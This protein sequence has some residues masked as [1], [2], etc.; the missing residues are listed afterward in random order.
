[1]RKFKSLTLIAFTALAVAGCSSSG[2]EV[3]D[4]TE[5]E[6]Y[7]KSQTYLQ[8]GD[9]SQAIRYLEAVKNRFPG[10]SYSEQTQLNLIYAYYKSQDY[11]KTLVTA[12]RFIQQFP[13]SQNLDY[14]LYMTGLTNFALGENFFQDFFGVD[15]ATRES[16]S[17]K[18]AFANFQTLVQHFPNSAYAQD[19]LARMAYI[20]ASLAR[21]ELSIAKFYAKRDAHVAV[22]NRVVGM[23][24]QYSDTQATLD[25]LP[26]MKE[27]YEKMNLTHLAN[28]TESLIQ[29]NQGKRFA[30][31]EKPAEPNL[32]VPQK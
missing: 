19:A 31:V 22:A 32:T 12:D 28:Q 30:D 9:Y 20:K 24:Q 29:A 4:G 15:R 21:H 14:V 18:A 23:L 2:K 26:L 5:Q 6:L 7:G 13:N 1:M 11:T 3:E 27:A 17:I 25:A 10:T 16:T 8:D